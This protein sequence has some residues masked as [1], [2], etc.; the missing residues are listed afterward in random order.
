MYSLLYNPSLVK[1]VF[2]NVGAAS[3]LQYHRI[4]EN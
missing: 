2:V 4:V 1:E 3:C